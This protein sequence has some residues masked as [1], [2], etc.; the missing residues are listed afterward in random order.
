MSTNLSLAGSQRQGILAIWNDCKV[1]REPEFETWYQIEHLIERLDVPGIAFGRRHEAVSASPQFFTFYVAETVEIFSS[2]PYIERLENPTPLTRQVMSE[3]FKN[4]SRTVCRREKCLGR[5]HGSTVVTTRF[6]DP[7]VLFDTA[8]PI[9]SILDDPGVA[10]LEMWRETE[11]EEAAIAEEERLRGGDQ[12][13]A[14]CLIVETLR[15]HTAESI[16][17]D[18]TQWFPDAETGVY[19]VLCDIGSDQI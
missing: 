8:L 14:A 11:P 17:A 6:S 19:Q 12:K 3:V 18:L 7:A 2:R 9:A 1:G 4:M 5:M 13:I 10:R 15:R 16:A